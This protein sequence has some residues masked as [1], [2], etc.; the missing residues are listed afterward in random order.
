MRL[1]QLLLQAFGKFH[2]AELDFRPGLN[3]VYGPNETGKSTVQRFIQGMLYGF[4]KP[5]ARR[6]TAAEEMERYAPWAGTTYRGVLTY[7]LETTGQRIRVERD[8]GAA[9]RVRV[10]DA[11]T[12]APLGF[13]QDERKELLF[14]QEH[15]GLSEAEFLRTAC[16]GQLQLRVSG[17]ADLAHRLN[18][19]RSTG[20]ETLSVKRV[21]D[22]LEGRRKDVMQRLR[23][24]REELDRSERELE[25]LAGDR[26][27]ALAGAAR[28]RTVEDDLQAARAALAARRRHEEALQ[29]VDMTAALTALQRLEARR[30]E[31]APWAQ[32]PV[33]LQAEADR[34]A[35]AVDALGEE[36][37]RARAE[38]QARSERH[39]AAAAA[40]ASLAGC[41]LLPPDAGAQASSLLTRWQD[42]Q[43]DRA[44]RRAPLGARRVAVAEQEARL[45]ALQG[46]GEPRALRERLLAVDTALARAGAREPAEWLA[47]L[48]GALAAAR[49]RAAT[50]APLFALAA[51]AG[52]AAAG[53]GLRVHPAY[54]ALLLL[55]GTLGALAAGAAAARTRA[56]ALTREMAAAEQAAREWE[57]LRRLLKVSGREE[58]EECLRVWVRLAEDVAERRRALAA[59][60]E[61]LALYAR[62]TVEAEAALALLLAPVA[63]LLPP[64]G[65]VEHR[66]RALQDLLQRHE[67]LTQA[68][69]AAAAEVQAAQRH[70]DRV[71]RDLAEAERRQAGLL[72]RAGAADRAAFAQ[73]CAA[74][75]EWRELSRHRE[76]VT[77]EL[78][79]QLGDGGPVAWAAAVA[80]MQGRAGA[81]AGAGAV[82][83]A[84]AAA[85]AETPA[86]PAAE[87]SERV[88]HLER[89]EAHLR[90]ALERAFAGAAA[91]AEQ[92]VRAAGQR[93]AVRELEDEKGALEVAKEHLVQAAEE[94]HREFAP[95]VNAR[96]AQVLPRLTGGRYAGVAVDEK[97]SVQVEVPGAGRRV[98]GE[99]LSAGTQ[100]QLYLAL[101]V[102]LLELLVPA[103]KT[104]PPL[105]LD[106]PFVQCDE[107]RLIGCMDLLAELAGTHQ[108]L[109]FT[110]HR[111]ELEFARSASQHVH[112]ILL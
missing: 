69:A 104:R 65:S 46:L 32:F 33:E 52:L 9:A 39:R 73:G 62:R 83:G 57:D 17:D 55:A 72:A 36:A 67:R 53:L 59:D 77:A 2:G 70:R 25:R 97:L 58:A 66:A 81:A 3:V 34:L 11:D 108:V 42:A 41:G 5:G 6:R 110:C 96:L 88:Q 101:R 64:A 43:S 63:G 112:T 18:N 29:L 98:A 24:R 23:P 87:L 38:A 107:A 51:V 111:R 44:R 105:I 35:G 14:A 19:L 106:D 15:T 40:L 50:A 109:L 82:A 56:G 89:E 102:A 86:L 8:F 68:A 93:I 75:L 49:R 95:Q 94:M 16:V 31:L 48:R 1:E 74:A 37:A 22:R 71:E 90:G 85:A 4:W 79:E 84:E 99:H 91:L 20:Q 12:G 21:L 100:D 80:E 13:P 92:E 78:A 103:G 10:A 27:E 76:Y 54:W 30:A 28:L 61:E 26:E 45:A 47:R 60:E 7:H